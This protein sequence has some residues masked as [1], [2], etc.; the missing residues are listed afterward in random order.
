MRR[1]TAPYS[2]VAE[3]ALGASSLLNI[4]K[5]YAN[6]QSSFFSSSYFFALNPASLLSIQMSS[7]KHGSIEFV[8][9]RPAL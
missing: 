5:Q 9:V 2:M 8:A 7:L 3:Q 6:E 1:R 4:C